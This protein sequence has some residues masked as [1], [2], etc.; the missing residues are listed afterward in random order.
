MKFRT[1]CAWCQTLMSEKECSAT[2]NS[3]ALSKD[4][5]MISHGLCPKCKRNLENIYGLNQGG[6]K[7]G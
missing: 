4:G 2:Q 5:V 1:V 7:N 6:N 3:L